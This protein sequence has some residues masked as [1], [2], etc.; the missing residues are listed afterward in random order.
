MILGVLG[1]VTV[2]CGTTIPLNILETG[3]RAAAI[4]IYVCFAI[5]LGNVLLMVFSQFIKSIED[6]I[7]FWIYLNAAL[8]GARCLH[9]IFKNCVPFAASSVRPSMDGSSGI[10]VPSST[11]FRDP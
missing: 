1:V 5:L 4:A 11:R 9:P 7:E 3:S 10:N 2:I 8:V 6:H